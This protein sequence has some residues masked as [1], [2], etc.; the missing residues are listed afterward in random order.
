[1]FRTVSGTF[2]LL[3]PLAGSRALSFP[4]TFSKAYCAH[5][6]HIVCEALGMRCRSRAGWQMAGCS[7][8][9]LQA[10]NRTRNWEP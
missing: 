6:L 7:G 1:M 8:D 2:A 5:S 9:V 10:K 3:L 4:R